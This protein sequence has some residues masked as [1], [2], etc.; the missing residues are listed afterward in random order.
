MLTQL[1]NKATSTTTGTG[2]TAVAEDQTVHTSSLAEL[3]KLNESNQKVANHLNKLVTIG[4]MT[5]KNTKDT[6]NN[7]ANVGSSLV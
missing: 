2:A 3:V 5:E 7:L 4:A 1:K 6:K